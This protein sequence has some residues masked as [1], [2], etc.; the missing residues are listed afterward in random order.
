[1]SYPSCL[2][3]ILVA[4]K[5]RLPETPGTC[6]VPK[7][8]L[9][10]LS[11]RA[12][13]SPGISY[14]PVCYLSAPRRALFY[15]SY[16]SCLR[17]ILVA[18]RIGSPRRPGRHASGECSFTADNFLD[19]HL[20]APVCASLA[21]SESALGASMRT[22]DR[23]V[24]GRPAEALRVLGQA[25]TRCLWRHCAACCASCG[26][27]AASSLLLDKAPELLRP[28]APAALTAWQA[29]G[30][31]RSR[32]H[33]QGTR[34]PAPPR[35]TYPRC[36]AGRPAD[37]DAPRVLPVVQVICE[38]QYAADRIYVVVCLTPRRALSST[39]GLL[40]V[41]TDKLNFFSTRQ[42]AGSRVGAFEAHGRRAC[43]G[44]FFCWRG[45]R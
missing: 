40:S 41:M 42:Q 19:T 24:A 33:C 5:K 37:S 18:A 13:T 8:I 3:A 16:P 35:P 12:S 39:S 28:R 22:V 29:A 21:P 6:A 43:S 11:R 2:R 31:K 26:L 10:H 14:R 27:L 25:L 4:A 1:L 7:V 44:I 38:Q 9:R 45:P 20:P 32:C 17:T 36:A 15:L 23:C 30:L 34:A